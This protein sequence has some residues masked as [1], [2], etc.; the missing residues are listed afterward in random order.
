MS[1]SA[2]LARADRLVMHA[3]EVPAFRRVEAELPIRCARA[4][5]SG[6]NAI[7]CGSGGVMVAPQLDAHARLRSTQT[8]VV[9][10][11]TSDGAA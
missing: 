4:R 11:E 5:P 3:G 9:V 10:L 2:R 6:R 8:P 7:V 1:Y